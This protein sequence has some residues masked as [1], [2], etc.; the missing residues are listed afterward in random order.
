MNDPVAEAL[1]A[2][3]KRVEALERQFAERATEPR[4]KDWRRGVGISEDN[5]FTRAMRAE[6]EAAR[7]ADRR[8]ARASDA[9]E[10]HIV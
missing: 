8:A 1:A 9:D 6:I 7:E 5:E 4:K 10:P 3:T 2:L